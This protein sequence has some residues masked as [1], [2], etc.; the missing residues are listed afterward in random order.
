MAKG[1]FLIDSGFVGIPVKK[2]DSIKV[3]NDLPEDTHRKNSLH[4]V[5]L[6]SKQK[7]IYLVEQHEFAHHRL[8]TSSLVGVLYWRMNQVF[9]RDIE[10][11]VDQ[12]SKLN[13]QPSSGMNLLEWLNTGGN[14]QL[15]NCLSEKYESDNDSLVSYYEELMDNV[16]NN[17]K[18]KD[19]LFGN[20]NNLPK[21]ITRG[22]FCDIFNKWNSWSSKRCDL[23]ISEENIRNEISVD[24]FDERLYISDIRTRKTDAPL[25]PD[26]YAFNLDDLIEAH[27]TFS[28]LFN[29]A[30]H[31]DDKGAKKLLENRLRYSQSSALMALMKYTTSQEWKLGFSPFL[32]MQKIYLLFNSKIDICVQRDTGTQYLEDILPWLIYK[33]RMAS[34]GIE[35]KLYLEILSNMETAIKSS[36]VGAK[37]NWIKY[38]LVSM[39]VLL[40]NPSPKI[41]YSFLQGVYSSSIHKALYVFH[42]NIFELY[43]LLAGMLNPDQAERSFAVRNW[44]KNSLEN[45]AL[46][47]YIDGLS[48]FFQPL[49]KA[50]SHIEAIPD[51]YKKPLVVLLGTIMSSAKT[52]LVKAYWLGNSIP[53]PKIIFDKLSQELKMLNLDQGFV[54]STSNLFV[55][56]YEYE[57]KQKF[58]NVFLDEDAL[59]YCDQ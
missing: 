13:L 26:G 56:L 20:F 33:E 24:R 19:I 2:N 35:K 30:T 36:M 58:N 5:K 59:L 22:E 43:K 31:N 48:M 40:D 16:S 29:L 18:L 37:S 27:A 28:E 47:E 55:K 54:S 14:V 53:H 7:K 4:W 32:A 42:D 11:V 51:I 3:Y 39:S 21:E 17:L 49:Q 25:F 45:L 50:N 46:I 8:L 34:Q 52:S 12:M 44:E 1:T 41:L 10:W 23:P 38:P 57:L 6:S 9:H 15:K